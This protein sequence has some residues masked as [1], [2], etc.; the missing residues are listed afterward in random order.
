[1][2]GSPHRRQSAVGEE[3]LR[4]F[5]P[6][7]SLPAL[8]EAGDAAQVAGCGLQAIDLYLLVAVGLPLLSFF[9]QFLFQI[10]GVVARIRAQVVTV[11]V[12][13]QD[14]VCHLIQEGSVV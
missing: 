2:F 9:G 1:M 5:I 10:G 14:P 12:D 8:A 6:T 4:K 7:V 11:R 3:S 13:L